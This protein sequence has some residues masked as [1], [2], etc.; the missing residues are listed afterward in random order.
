MW[1]EDNNW[2]V[3]SLTIRP[4]LPNPLLYALSLKWHHP[5]SKFSLLHINPF[6]HPL[7]HAPQVTSSQSCPSWNFNQFPCR[8]SFPCPKAASEVE[9]KQK[10]A[11]RNIFPLQNIFVCPTTSSVFTFFHS[12]VIKRKRMK[13]PLICYI[14][15]STESARNKSCH[16]RETE[17]PSHGSK[18]VENIKNIWYI[19][20]I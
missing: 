17:P 15:T 13:F 14:D 10:R 1:A 3:T 5:K 12:S 7:P 20:M 16:R 4:P 2:H 9:E 19:N 11:G 8:N 18:A 6:P